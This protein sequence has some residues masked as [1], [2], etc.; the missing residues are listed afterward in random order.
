MII[1]GLLFVAYVVVVITW[2]VRGHRKRMREL[3]AS[4]KAH[5]RKRD[6]E[7]QQECQRIELE[8]QARLREINERYEAGKREWEK[9]DSEFRGVCSEC[10]EEGE[11]YLSRCLQRRLCLRNDECTDAAT[12]RFWGKPSGTKYMGKIVPITHGLLA[13]PEEKG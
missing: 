3:D 9:R 1:A 2:A 11:T 12:R 10:G 7:Y 4:F 5:K 13:E 6:E 8:H